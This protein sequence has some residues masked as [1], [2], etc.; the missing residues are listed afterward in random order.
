[1]A[2]YQ[3]RRRDPLLDQ[4]MQA[5]LERRGREL[6]GIA[7]ICVAIAFTLMLLSYSPDDPGWMVATDATA[8]NVLGRLGAAIASTLMTIGGMGA[9]G[10]PAVVLAW[11]VRFASHSGA[12]RA[13]SRIVFAVI[14][15]ALGSVYAAT[16]VP[17]VGWSP[18]FG[19]GGLFGDTICGSLIGIVPGG[20][21]IALKIVSFTMAVAFVAMMLFVTG[22]NFRELI[23]IARFLAL[24]LVVAYSGILALMG[25]GAK[26]TIAEIGRAHV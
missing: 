6:F 22:F 20:A 12:E 5:M 4:T 9:W 10:I 1:M 14:A 23:Q 7:L 26:G 17:P 19:L 21:A 3:A 15:V 24:G 13:L 2:S 25:Q 8:H 18:N 16:L 11:G